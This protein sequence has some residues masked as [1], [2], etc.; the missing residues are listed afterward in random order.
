MVAGEYGWNLASWTGISD[1]GYGMGELKVGSGR[2]LAGA[3]MCIL[4]SVI[5]V[6]DNLSPG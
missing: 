3:S 2:T 1:L 6:R 4:S 5:N